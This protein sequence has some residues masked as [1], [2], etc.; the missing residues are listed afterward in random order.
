MKALSLSAILFGFILPLA[1][2]KEETEVPFGQCPAPV[3]AMI[4]QNAQQVRGT[5]EKV[6]KE[7]TK[8]S[9]FYDAKIA[10]AD[11]RHWSLK[12]LPDGK[13]LEWKEKKAKKDK[14]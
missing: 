2:A 9:E 10:G 5:V 3:Q 1:S 13:V 11:G 7:K 6:E 12:V 14:N 8:D 4:K